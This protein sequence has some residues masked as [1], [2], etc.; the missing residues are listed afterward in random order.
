MLL[1]S[2]LLPGNTDGFP[3]KPD[4]VAKSSPENRLP[5]AAL[6]EAAALIAVRL[7]PKVVK[8]KMTQRENKQRLPLA[9]NRRSRH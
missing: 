6:Q 3:N 8:P 4:E 5:L 2:L 1:L 7:L 9:L